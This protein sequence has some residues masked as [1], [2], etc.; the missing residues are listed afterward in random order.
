MTTPT[1]EISTGANP[2][3]GVSVRIGFLVKTFPR[4]SETFILNEILGLE[5]LGWSLHLYSLKRPADEPSHPVV[6]QVKAPVTYIPSL[7]PTDSL[8]DPLR[9]VAV[10]ASLIVRRPLRYLSALR[11]YFLG[12]KE[13]HLREFAQ[14]GY[15]AVSLEEAGLTH[16]HAHFANAPTAVAE[17]VF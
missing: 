13:T 14:A 3:A 11:K 4:L 8:L 2:M 15:L 1:S 12:T 7:L 5:Q 6:D 9:V 10:H 17:I 16:I